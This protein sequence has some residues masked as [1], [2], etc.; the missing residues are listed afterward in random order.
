MTLWMILRPPGVRRLRGAVF[1]RKAGK[2]VRTRGVDVVGSTRGLEI[3]GRVLSNSRVESH[4]DLP[5]TFH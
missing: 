3:L 4:A 1:A 5:A 2:P